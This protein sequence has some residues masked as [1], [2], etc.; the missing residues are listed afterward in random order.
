M[1]EGYEA[2]LGIRRIT[3]IIALKALYLCIVLE[4]VM[5]TILGRN[6]KRK[7]NNGK[8]CVAAGCA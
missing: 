8:E 1:H 2:F 7:E 5:Y 3:F 4:I 6:R